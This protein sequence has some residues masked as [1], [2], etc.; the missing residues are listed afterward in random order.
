MVND[1]QLI[2]PKDIQRGLSIVRKN[3]WIVVLLTLI[4]AFI[5]YIY[6]YKQPDLY[7]TRCQILL[8][9]NDQFNQGSIISDVGSYYG[10]SYRT[11]IDNSNE[12]RV[13]TSYDLI[14]QVIERLDFRVSYFVVGRLKTE[15]IFNGVPF[16]VEV[17]ALN[18]ELYEK[19]LKFSVTGPTHYEIVY[20]RDDR[21][22]RVIGIFGKRLVNEDMDILVS[23]T[24]AFKLTGLQKLKEAQYLMQVHKL[25]ALVQLY[26]GSLK[27]ENP[28]FTNILELSVRDEIPARGM[29][30]LDTLAQ[31]YIENSLM[32]RVEINK[33]TIYFID[34]QLNEVTDIL[35]HIED[36]MLEY[37]KDQHILDLNREGGEYFSQYLSLDNQK[38]VL[39]LQ[40][41]AIDD[42][43][44]YIIEDKDPQFLPPSLYLI[45]NDPFLNRSVESLYTMQLTL[46]EARQTGTA[47]NPVIKMEISKIDSLK[48]DMLVYI[49][50]SKTA[51]SERIKSINNQIESSIKT[52][53]EIPEKQR[54]LTNIDRKLKV[55][56]GM[57]LFL[58]QRKAN[59]V[60]ARA[61]IVPDTKVIEKARQLG[62]KVSPNMSKILY[63]SGGIGLAL[64]LLIVF[65][66]LIFYDRIETYEEMKSFT[67]LP[68]VGEII[69]TKITE[70]L[71]IAVEHDPKSPIAEAFRTVRT[72]LQY[73]A[74]EATPGQGKMIVITSYNPGEGKTYCSINLAAILAKT[75]K[76]VLLLE[77]D[78]HKPRVQKG[79][80]IETDKG[81]STYVIG[82]HAI[83]EIVINTQVENLD[84]IFAGALP[85]NPSELVMSAKI[86]EIFEWGRRNYEYVIVD[87]PPV[88]LLSDALV[89]MKL[90]DV[91]LFVVNVKF[92]YRNVLRQVHEIVEFHNLQHFGFLLNGVKKKKSRYYY[93]RYGYGYGYGGYG[94]YSGGY[95]GYGS[96]GS[97]GSSS[98]TNK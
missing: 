7:A 61:G 16:D 6:G 65:V 26:Q 2:N 50:N 66:R 36:T 23:P 17:D 24:P 72:N 59:T 75:G 53:Q 27:V 13:I 19:M 33:N 47:K 96:Y 81:F 39:E 32:S 52:I 11:Y 57:Y 48:R 34:R 94:K 49:T 55:N 3:W 41:E 83:E 79:L 70:E 10:N 15:E 88:G 42:L 64:A 87:T 86:Q 56:E 40:S 54:G 28:E 92:A 62:K 8:K 14:K 45:S 85:P 98:E 46:N 35:N 4:G 76:R 90:S 12:K 18:N 58:L 20:Y 51:I 30:F 93:N 68:I 95:G 69:Q 77:L 82:K 60:I 73:L 21:E 25:Q 44:N 5:G 22:K 37:K 74:G 84:V 91:N 63:I 9:S 71:K 43:R 29:M 80:G 31:V 67:T 89:L 97:Y 1:N 78:L 38:R